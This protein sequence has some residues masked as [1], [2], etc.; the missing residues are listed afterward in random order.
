[1][2][3]PK[4]ILSFYHYVRKGYFYSINYEMHANFFNYIPKT[5]KKIVKTISKDNAIK[6]ALIRILRELD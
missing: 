1:M 6:K 2:E 5:K 3:F 4:S